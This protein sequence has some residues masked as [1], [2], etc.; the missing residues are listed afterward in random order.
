MTADELLAGKQCFPDYE[1]PLAGMKIGITGACGSLGSA[2]W[3]LCAK[4]KAEL[5]GIDQNE[6][7]VAQAQAE[8]K[9]IELGDVGWFD[10]EV[11]VLFHC[12]AYKHVVLGEKYPER[13]HINNVK[14]TTELLRKFSDVRVVL[15]STDKVCGTSQMGKSK[16][17][18]EKETVK[19]NQIAVRLVN[20]V[21]SRGSVVDLWEQAV[22]KQ[23]QIRVAPPHVKRMW[24]QQEDA[25][26]AMV[27]SITCG[28]GLYV[29]HHVPEFTMGELATAFLRKHNL[30]PN[31]Y[32][33]MIMRPG[34]AT[35]ERLMMSSERFIETRT[36]YLRR[37]LPLNKAA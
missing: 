15:A 8:G 2:I 9:D 11:D 26:Y 21:G 12:A 4:G 18:A 35:D 36:P 29:V 34:E 7:A 37:V 20:I 22:R 14:R 32:M 10:R 31:E 27:R 13:F 5:C 6:E 30:P 1:A 19:R 33:A 25:A 24:F 23:Q 16:L 17:E 28:P 3:R